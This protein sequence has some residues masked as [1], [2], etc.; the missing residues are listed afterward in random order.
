MAGEQQA[1]S[2]STQRTR[3]EELRAHV[4]EREDDGTRVQLG[5]A[6]QNLLGERLGNRRETDERRRL[7]VVDDV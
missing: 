4:G 2:N 5:H 7:D 3:P 6:R 1:V